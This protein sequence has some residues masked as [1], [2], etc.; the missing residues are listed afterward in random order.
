M[1]ADYVTKTVRKRKSSENDN[2]STKLRNHFNNIKEDLE[3]KQTRRKTCYGN[4]GSSKKKVLEE[5]NN[6]KLRD[7]QVRVDNCLQTA[8]LPAALSALCRRSFEL[9]ESAAASKAKSEEHT[10]KENIVSM[11]DREI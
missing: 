10:L 7:V 3:N 2:V 9:E 1:F 8:S 11:N 5:A 4:R 6:S